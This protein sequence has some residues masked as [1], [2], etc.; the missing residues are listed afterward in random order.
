MVLWVAIGGR[1]TIVGGLVGAVLTNSAKTVFSEM[2]PD[3]WPI[4]LGGM[5]IVVVLFLQEG[6]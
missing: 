5:F 1:A 6:L 3:G 4:I 2:F